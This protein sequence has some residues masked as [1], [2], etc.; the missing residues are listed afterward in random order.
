M[1]SMVPELLDKLR[2]WQRFMI[3][4]LDSLSVFAVL[5]DERGKEVSPHYPLIMMVQETINGLDFILNGAA[6]DISLATV[7]SYDLEIKETSDG[8]ALERFE[9]PF[10]WTSKSVTIHFTGSKTGFIE[11]LCPKS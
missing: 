3:D 5:V 6:F 10:E 9:V 7:G 11:Q 2:L 8:R 4:K 1:T